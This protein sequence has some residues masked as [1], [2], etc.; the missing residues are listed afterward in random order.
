MR[1]TQMYASWAAMKQRTTP[2]SAAQR[3]NP[4]YIGVKRDPLWDTFEGFLSNP[5]AGR[6]W[7]RGMQLT[8]RG[9]VGDYTPSNC[10]WRS[11]SDNRSEMLARRKLKLADG[12]FAADVAREN[13]VPVGTWEQRYYKMG[14]PLE[15]AVSAK[16]IQPHAVSR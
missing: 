4:S 14:W 11:A 8:R 9:D 16:R 12:R 13:G 15:I 5:P 3:S 7:S 10:R 2:G 6:P 1:G